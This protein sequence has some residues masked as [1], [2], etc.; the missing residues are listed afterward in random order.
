MEKMKRLLRRLLPMLAVLLGFCGRDRMAGGTDEVQNPALQMGLVDAAGHLHRQGKLRIYSRLQNP[1]HDSLPILTQT[2]DSIRPTRIEAAR[3]Y[4]AMDSAQKR[5]LPWDNRDTL[6]FNI[7]AASPG[8]EALGQGFLLVRQA[9]GALGFRR[10]W[11]WGIQN[12]DSLGV[13]A[14]TL[15]VAPPVLAFQGQVGPQGSALAIQGVFIPGT[16]YQ[17]GVG[18]DGAFTLTRLARGRFELHAMTPDL[19]TYRSQ[20][21]LNTDSAFTARNWE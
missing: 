7:V 1:L 2:V 11:P 14:E 17:A 16:P 15:Q 13:L 20:D 8:A 21:T 12:P 19:R 5:G 6:E 10:L 4:A 18:L 3:L 9:G